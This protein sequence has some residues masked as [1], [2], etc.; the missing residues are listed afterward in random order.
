MTTDHLPLALNSGEEYELLF[1]AT[2]ENAAK[3]DE[4]SNALVVPI[5]CIGEVVAS[6]ELQLQTGERLEPLPR[7]GYEHVI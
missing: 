3:I 4:L 6:G 7:S 1:T 2:P 5:T